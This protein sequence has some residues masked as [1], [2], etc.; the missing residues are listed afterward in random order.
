MKQYIFE[1]KNNKVSILKKT[2]RSVFSVYGFLI[3]FIVMLLLMPFFIFSFLL[4]EIKGGNLLYKICRFWAD[5]FF[6]LI[7]IHPENIY[8]GKHD[9]HREYIFVSNHISYLD[10]PMIMKAIRH[11]H[12]RILGKAEM[13]KVP[14]FG[15]I[16]K[17]GAVLVDRESQ[18]KRFESVKNLIYFLKRKISVFICPEGTFNT[19]HKP[20][21]FFYS[22]A[23]K[24]AIE[25]QKPIRPI[26]F[27]DTYDR[28]SYTNVFSLN[29]G[30]CRAVY[31]AETSTEGLTMHDVP[32]LKEKIYRQMEDALI[33]YHATWIMEQY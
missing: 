17:K 13:T 14:I 32:V 19:T 25:T 2:L 18:V 33:R 6:F 31:L 1:Y 29:P 9:I 22:G 20:L 21:K 27:L 7:G 5:A 28:L 10:I 16:Y 8:E 12:V 15:Y 4:P 11:Q 26:L 30:R 3:F 23:F 24:I